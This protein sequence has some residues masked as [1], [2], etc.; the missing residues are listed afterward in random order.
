[1]NLLIIAA[2]GQIA[3]IVEHRIL[4]EP[5]FQDVHLTLMLRRPQRLNELATNSRVT[6]LDGD[7]S[8]RE[9]LTAAMKDQDLVYVAVVDTSTDNLWTRNVIVAM[10]KAAVQRVIFSNGLGI[11]DEVGGPFGR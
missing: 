8:D 3:R 5:A 1:M 10:Q 6:L 7:L 11:Y 4:T 9:G 2:N